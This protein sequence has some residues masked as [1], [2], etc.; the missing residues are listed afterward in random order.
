MA[1]TVRTVPELQALL[2]DAAAAHSTNRQLLRDMLVSLDAIAAGGLGGEVGAR[3]AGDAT[4][5]SSAED[6]ADAGDVTAVSAAADYTDAELVAVQKFPILG[7]ETGVT[8]PTYPYGDVRRFGAVGDGT[9]DDYAAFAAAHDSLPV[10][11]GVIVVPPTT[12]NIY[13]LSQAWNITKPCRVT[14]CLPTANT[15]S[16]NTGTVLRFDADK[17]GVIVNNYITIDETTR[18]QDAA[19]PGANYAILENLDVVSAGGIDGLS[20]GGT[21]VDVDGIKIRAPGVTVR[22]CWCRAWKRDGIRIRADV[23]G[24]GALEGNAN[25]WRLEHCYLVGNGANGLYTDG[26]DANAGVALSVDATANGEWGIYDS[27][28]L[29]N[30]YIACHTSGNVTGPYKT[31]S[32]TGANLFLGCYQEGSLG[33]TS[34]VSPTVV[35]GGN[36]PSDG[37]LSAAS[38]AFLLGPGISFRAQL[39]AQNTTGAAS[40]SS[41]LVLNDT[42]LT[43]FTFGSSDEHAAMKSNQLQYD[44]VNKWW[45]LINSG[46]STR[47][48]IRFPSSGLT[49]RA[50]APLFEQGIYIGGFTSALQ[51]TTTGSAAPTSGTWVKGDRV[52]NNYTVKGTG[53]GI[54]FWLCTLAGTPGT[55][56]ANR[57][58][59]TFTCAANTLTTVTETAVTSTSRIIIT[60]TNAAAG[61]LQAGTDALYVSAKTGATSFAVRTAAGG[62]AAGTETFD[63]VIHN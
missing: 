54:E 31:D 26:A 19:K 56:V 3:I 13:R 18:A 24:G 4:T 11:G 45:S 38:T 42:T 52:L 44:S 62:A 29:G 40:V 61:T 23:G 25:L 49:L 10:T 22:N 53:T 55:W 8:N 27:S 14:G 1:D 7:G 6:Y 36:L 21:G 35:L 41:G 9:T 50:A 32:V 34:L 51:H 15:Y 37:N 33:L 60:P 16:V 39:Q 43:A 30:T 48:Y 12:T 57:A 58:M 28:F 63:Y 46:S 2:A 47:R 17:H 5:L 59:G 20:N